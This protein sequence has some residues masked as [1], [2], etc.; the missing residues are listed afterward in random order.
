[1]CCLSES[2]RVSLFVRELVEG[3]KS[4]QVLAECPFFTL[5]PLSS[6]SQQSEVKKKR[7]QENS[8]A[9]Q[10]HAHTTNVA[11]TQTVCLVP[12]TNKTGQTQQRAQRTPTLSR[13]QSSSSSSSSRHLALELELF[14]ANLGA[15]ERCAR[16]IISLSL[17]KRTNELVVCVCVCV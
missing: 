15:C 13:S 8:I 10:T 5:W 3:G 4:C 14:G 16:I 7:K 12:T 17:A 9:A 2:W 6:S 1:M 11:H